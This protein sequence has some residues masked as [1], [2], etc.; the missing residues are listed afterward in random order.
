MGKPHPIDLRSRVIACVEKGHRH[1]EAA[2]HFRVSPR[3]VNDAVSLKR[4]SGALLPK[5]QGNHAKGKLAPFDGW[6]RERLAVKGDL[7]LDEIVA[8]IAAVAGVTVHRAS[9]GRWL[10]RLGLSHKKTLLASEILRPDVA[11]RRRV[12]VET[13]QHDMA[14]MLAR[15]VCIDET[16]MKTNLFKTTGWAPVGKRLI[17]RT[18]FGHWHTQTYIAGLAHDGLIAPWALDGAMNR[19]SFKT[20]IARELAPALRPGQ[21][22]VADNLASHKSS[23]AIKL[24]RVQ[25]ND[26]IFRSRGNPSTG[27]ISLPSNPHSPDLNPIEMAFSKL[28]TLIRKAAARTNKALWRQLGAVCD[29]FLPQECRNYF[30]AAGYGLNWARHTLSRCRRRSGQAC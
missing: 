7:T 22:V 16:S 29:L 15:L 14:N 19:D 24:L 20:Y 10:H 27:R 21:I 25:G 3:F 4:A 30:I 17:D 18:P 9:V 6:L 12:W 8:E 1:R 28:K 26:L 2:R 13:H 11:E 5:P 23:C